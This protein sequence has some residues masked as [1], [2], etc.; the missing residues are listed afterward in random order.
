MKKALILV[1]ALLCVFSTACAEE[2]S[3][4]RQQAG[5][6]NLD[7]AP[8]GMEFPE[9]MTFPEGMDMPEGIEFPEGMERPE[10][11]GRQDGMERPSGGRPDTQGEVQGQNSVQ[12]GL[13]EDEILGKVESITGNRVE[14]LLGT[15]KGGE[16]SY[17]T[18]VAAYL[19]PVG[20]KIGSSDFSSVS[21]GM[22]LKLSMGEAS[23]GTETITAVTIVTR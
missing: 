3:A 14:L 23:D 13:E 6:M 5:G 2:T 8:E 7:K 21:A 15:L 10:G 1:L 4:G 9:G 22:V 18:E 20:M 16:I 19:L 11:M 12:L 17:G